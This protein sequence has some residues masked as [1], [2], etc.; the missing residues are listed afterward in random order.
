MN[1]HFLVDSN[2]FI[3][4]LLLLY[5]RCFTFWRTVIA[6]IVKQSL[7]TDCHT[8]LR[9]IRKEAR[10]SGKNISSGNEKSFC[11]KRS[12]S[13]VEMAFR[14]RST[15]L[16]HLENQNSFVTFWSYQKVEEK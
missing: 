9:F 8:S 7:K 11:S 13:G 1:K 3:G 6:N 14:L 16:W 10:L 2:F 12:L 15:T 4:Q 5:F